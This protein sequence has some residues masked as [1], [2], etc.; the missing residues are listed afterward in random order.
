MALR[1]LKNIG[2]AA[3]SLEIK[4]EGWGHAENDIRRMLDKHGLDLKRDERDLDLSGITVSALVAIHKGLARASKAAAKNGNTVKAS[5][6]GEAAE[7]DLDALAKE[8]TPAEDH[9]ALKKIRK[10]ASVTSKAMLRAL[11]LMG[12]DATPFKEG[13]KV[14]GI[15][16]EIPGLEKMTYDIRYGYFSAPYLSVSVPDGANEEFHP[17]A[18]DDSAAYAAAK[19]YLADK[20][21]ELLGLESPSARS[22]LPVRARD[23]R[24]DLTIR[25]CPVCF[26]DIKASGHT[27]GLIA[28]HGYTIDPGYRTGHCAGSGELPWEKSCDPAVE[29]IV[30]LLKYAANIKARLANL[31][32][33]K[34]ASLIV[35]GEYDWKTRSYGKVTLTSAD[36]RDWK[37]ALKTA[38]WAAELTHTRLW[39]GDYGSIPWMRMAVRTWVAVSDADIAVGAPSHPVTEAD[40]V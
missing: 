8:P 36:G 37:A 15:T 39:S 10:N 9:T 25:T 23:Y 14:V 19:A 24:T 21:S 35:R 32:G 18:E 34:V 29:E 6:L 7:Y 26:R 17:S 38:I 20:A 5:Y 13:R 4:E 28:D 3:L 40:R 27:N 1:P 30:S 11:D 33:D 31:K 2:I 22:G 16:V 12:L